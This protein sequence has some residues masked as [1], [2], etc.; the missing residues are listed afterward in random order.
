M[1]EQ[2]TTKDFE[3]L[4][5]QSNQI[6][7]QIE[8]V[9]LGSYKTKFELISQYVEIE[10]KLLDAGKL[11]L[12]DKR[13]FAS[14]ISHKLTDRGVTFSR[15]GK[16]FYVLFREEEKRGTELRANHE[17]NS[18]AFT[19]HE[20]VESSRKVI[21]QEIDDEYTQTLEYATVILEQ[22][23]DICND[24]IVKYKGVTVIKDG[25]ETQVNFREEVKKGIGDLA[26][27]KDE[28]KEFNASL[29]HIAQNNDLRN[30]A[31]DWKKI[32]ALL[33]EKVE[34]NIAKVAQL[35]HISPKHMSANIM[36]NEQD[37]LM[38][39]A[40]WFDVVD[41]DIDCSNCGASNKAVLDIGDWFNKQVER[42]NLSL[43]F[44]K[45]QI[46]HIVK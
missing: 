6:L 39:K 8:Q 5:K 25:V 29:E 30:K 14:Y 4:H 23:R 7:A 26:Q 17:N 3:Y 38:Q 15:S 42:M 2:L 24:V 31:R 19:K 27:F 37:D 45:P 36:K 18:S 12:H 9:E 11:E 28:L 33:L 20:P 16:D 35:I 43:P 44:K 34:Y 32:K 1:S 40:K 21:R 22:A 46:T 41:C 13:D 10:R